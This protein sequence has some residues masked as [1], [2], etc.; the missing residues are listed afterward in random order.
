MRYK[1]YRYGKIPIS[2]HVSLTMSLTTRVEKKSSL[3]FFHRCSSVFVRSV[4]L[5]KLL[6]VVVYAV[7][8][9]S[10]RYFD[11]TIKTC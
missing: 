7:V 11:V 9:N 10:G 6:C 8:V 1:I 5:I 4:I 2:S 3:V